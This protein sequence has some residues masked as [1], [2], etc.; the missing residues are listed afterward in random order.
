MEEE[1]MEEEELGSRRLEVG[2]EE[3]VSRSSE[4]RKEDEPSEASDF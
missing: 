4:G 1:A 2:V 3:I